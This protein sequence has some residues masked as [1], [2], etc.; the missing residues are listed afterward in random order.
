MTRVFHSTSNE[1][2]ARIEAIGFDDGEGSYGFV[3]HTLRGVFV[4]I[5]PADVN[6]GATHDDVI[7]AV[8]LPA[9]DLEPYWIEED[10]PHGTIRWEACVP[11]ELLNRYGPPVR[12]EWDDDAGAFLDLM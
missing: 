11:A 5:Q 4:G 2:A 8:N 9:S 3:G 7:L 6:D 12:V 10:A 1:A